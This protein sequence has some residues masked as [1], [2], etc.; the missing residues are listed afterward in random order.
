MCWLGDGLTNG[1]MMLVD[2]E[3]EERIAIE[4]DSSEM[5]MVL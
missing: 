1:V 4:D 3:M 5:L 2:K